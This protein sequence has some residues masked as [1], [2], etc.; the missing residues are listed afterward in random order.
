MATGAEGAAEPDAEA[1]RR[2]RPWILAATI[3]ASSM[4]FIDST[5]VHVALPR[6]QADL[7]ASFAEAQWVSNAYMLMLGG[8]IL[9]GGGLGDRLGR[10]RVFVGGLCA[11]TAASALCA[12]APDG[13]FLIA[14]RALQGAGAAVMTPQSL[15]ILSAAY[16]RAERG[17]AIGLWAA[18][19]A[20][21][22]SLG[23]AAGSLLIDG[24][25]WRWAFWVN[26]P[27]GALALVLALRFVPESRDVQAGPLDWPGALLATLGCGALAFG[28]TLAA[29]GGGARAWGLCA[30]GLAALAGFVAQEGRAQAPIMPLALFGSR[31]FSAINGATFLLYLALGSMLFLVP[32][33]LGAR[34]DWAAWETSLTLLPLGVAI[35]ALS[36]PAGALADRIGVRPM[37]TL[38]A[39]IVAAACAWAS[40]AGEGAVGAAGPMIVL[41][42]GMSA[43]VAPLSAGVMAAA[44]D[45][46]A[47]AA[48]GVS[49]AASR[50]AN[51]FA[52][53]GCGAVASA[54]HAA[55]SGPG[56]ATFGALPPIGDP[57]R[58]A[59][60]AAYLAGYGAALRLAA[61]MALAASALSWMGLRRGS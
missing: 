17:R 26:L 58:A 13:P 29:E 36:R 51:L 42:L 49:N 53:A 54:V 30:L 1:L 32:F 31:A 45:A 39:G 15:A 9:A 12:L 24:L 5:L 35:A 50:L 4:G 34:R 33:D 14:A 44:P 25:G 47:G 6:L 7:G 52:V 41:A 59:A 21:T 20:A 56:A 19:A 46:Q 37:L 55:A 18:A 10:R 60:E 57:A 38:G 8:L 43:V 48:S 40:L 2:R 11:F 28:L 3:V 23:P 22:T 61:A 16:P 27:F